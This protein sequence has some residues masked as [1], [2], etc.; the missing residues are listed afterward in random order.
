MPLETISIL[1]DAYSIYSSF[2]QTDIVELPVPVVTA[3]NIIK[4]LTVAIGSSSDYNTGI[5]ATIHTLEGIPISYV[6]T[7]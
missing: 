5:W 1:I 2:T 4:I 7:S 6:I 3:R